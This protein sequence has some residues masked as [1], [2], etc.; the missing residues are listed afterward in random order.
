MFRGVFLLAVFFCVTDRYIAGP[1]VH[2][3][4]DRLWKGRTL[5]NQMVANEVELAVLGEDGGLV[6]ERSVS[7]SKH[8]TRDDASWLRGLN[9]VA[10]GDGTAIG[11]PENEKPARRT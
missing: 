6:L 5:L 11:R 1:A 9:Q 8:E 7:E 3:H 2:G 4:V 10:V